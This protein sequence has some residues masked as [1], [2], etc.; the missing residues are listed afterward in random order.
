MPEDARLE[1]GEGEGMVDSWVKKNGHTFYW[2][3]V[4]HVGDQSSDSE[5]IARNIAVEKYPGL[6]GRETN[7]VRVM[8]LLG[9]GEGGEK[10]R[11]CLGYEEGLSHWMA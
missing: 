5:Y 2:E 10:F 9:R 1:T 4:V 3:V 11:F 7:F 6:G 8:T